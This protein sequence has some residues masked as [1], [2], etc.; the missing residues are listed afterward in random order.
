QIRRGQLLAKIIEIAIVSIEFLIVQIEAGKELV[1][2]KNIIR[3]HR[4][5][6]T[7]PQIKR[8]Q[9]L[10]TPDQ[11]SELR[12]KRRARLALI[13]RLQKRIVLRLNHPLRRQSLSENP[14]QRA[15]PHSYGAFNRNVTGKLEKLGH[16]M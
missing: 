13:K 8:P 14:R 1:F 9:L 16:G 11:K 10:E 3:H 15:L 4:L 12:L 6:R 2:L 5:V 7:R